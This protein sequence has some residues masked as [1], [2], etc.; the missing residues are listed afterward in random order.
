MQSKDHCL[1]LWDSG[2]GC[3]GGMEE[4]MGIERVIIFRDRWPVYVFA[5]DDTASTF[6]NWGGGIHIFPPALWKGASIF[7]GLY[8]PLPPSFGSSH[9]WH[10]SESMKMTMHFLV[11]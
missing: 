8:F 7:D 5:D 4:E 1:V 3:A 2:D 6:S 11:L 9:F 10:E